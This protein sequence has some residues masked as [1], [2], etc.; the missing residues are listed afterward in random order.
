VEWLF[1]AF[2]TEE[3][4]EVGQRITIV[5]AAQVPI[6]SATVV[7]LPLNPFVTSISPSKYTE[8]AAF[9]DLT[10]K[11]NDTF[12]VTGGVRWARNEQDY[13]QFSGGPLTRLSGAPAAAGGKSDE[14]VVTYMLSP[15]IRFSENTMLYARVATGYRPGGPNAALPGI[16]PTVDADTLTNYEVGLKSQSFGRRLLVE[17]GIFHIDWEDIQLVVST[18]RGSYGANGGK[19]KSRGLELN[20]ALLATQALRLG[21]NLAYTDA[22]LSEDVPELDGQSGDRLSETPTWSGALTADYRFPVGARWDGSFGGGF[23]YVGD[24][25]S[26]VESSPLALKAES[27]QVL[28]LNA[29]LSNDRWNVRIFA[30]NVTDEGTYLTLAIVPR[31]EG[32]VLQPRTIG[33]SVDT[34]F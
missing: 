25:Y 31:P 18:P 15:R 34:K 30:R 23:R 29:G 12:D 17:L 11:F 28:D 22:T 4:A 24:R 7:G 21:F 5:D 16:P 26:D 3:K 14:D 10:F 1:G 20:T 2:Y 32:V 33:I 6:S 9:G 27:Y 19:A 8:Y 13:R